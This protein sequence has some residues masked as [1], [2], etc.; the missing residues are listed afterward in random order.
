MSLK[1][2]LLLGGVGLAV[3]GVAMGAAAWYFVL[4]NDAPPPVSLE[5]ALESLA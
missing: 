5:A 1:S 2:K 3:A 4:R